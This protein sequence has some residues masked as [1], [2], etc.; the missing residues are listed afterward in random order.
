MGK[1]SCAGATD[2]RT[3]QP[4]AAQPTTGAKNTGSQNEFQYPSQSS[5]NGPQVIIVRPGRVRQLAAPRAR[6]PLAHRCRRALRGTGA[7]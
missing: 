5:E 7:G 2:L 1:P 3:S 4:H 6:I